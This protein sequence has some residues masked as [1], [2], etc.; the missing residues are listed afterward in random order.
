MCV[1]YCLASP[2]RYRSSQYL[3]YGFQYSHSQLG[4]LGPEAMCFLLAAQVVARGNDQRDAARIRSLLEPNQRVY[5]AKAREQLAKDRRFLSRLGLAY[6]ATRSA[7]RYR[8]ARA[9]PV[10]PPDVL[11]DELESCGSKAGK[12]QLTNAGEPIF[13]VLRTKAAAYALLG[14]LIGSPLGLGV[15]PLTRWIATPFV[16]VVSWTVGFIRGRRIRWDYCSDCH[17]DL[18]ADDQ[19]CPQCG[20]LIQGTVRSTDELF[21]AY[22]R[23]EKSS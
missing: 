10:L 11:E 19:A 2:Y 18:A 13:R 17:A 22:E 1:S 7:D 21:E 9:A 4:Y 20:G 3:S 5:F 14:I 8:E 16:I 23:L 15:G 6:L 12:P